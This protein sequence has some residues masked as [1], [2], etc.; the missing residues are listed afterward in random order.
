MKY[1]F[2]LDDNAAICGFEAFIN[3]K[4]IVGRVEEKQKARVEYKE[5]VEKGHG[6]YLME[7]AKPVRRH[8]YFWGS[9]IYFSYFQDVLTMNIGNLPPGCTC[10]IKLTYV[11]EVTTEAEDLIF[12]IPSSLAPWDRSEAQKQAESMAIRYISSVFLS[13][14]HCKASK[15][16]QKFF[17]CLTYH[18]GRPV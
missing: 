5:A 17:Q 7:A 1:V 18:R 15:I 14:F 3:G 16:Q 10:V 4:R 9:M 11:T 12:T 2:P 13:Y 8:Y 6:A